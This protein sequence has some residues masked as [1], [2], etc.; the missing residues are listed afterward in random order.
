MRIAPFIVNYMK[1][2]LREPL[3]HFLPDR[4]AFFR[5][6]TRATCTWPDRR[7]RSAAISQ[8]Q[9]PNSSSAPSNAFTAIA[10]AP[11]NRQIVYAGNATSI[12][13]SADAGASW[14][15]V[16]SSTDR[17]I[18][19]F[20][21]RRT[22]EVVAATWD[23]MN[24]DGSIYD[25]TDLGKSF[26][27]VFANRGLSTITEDDRGL[28]WTGGKNYGI[29]EAA[30]HTTPDLVQWTPILRYQDIAAAVDCP[31]GTV[32]HDKCAANWCVLATQLGISAPDCV[33]AI[34]A[35]PLPGTTGGCCDGS[36]GL[37]GT[38]PGLVAIALVRR[39]PRR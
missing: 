35:P 11:S 14:T 33:V 29:G 21:A 27:V 17:P 39:R 7:A 22:G 12:Y 13:R 9:T 16:L 1:R 8:P 5:M 26:G 37:A 24:M 30:I 3:L 31:A 32:Q 2:L 18:D 19:A 15:P 10:F 6:C 4:P 38:L 20:A 28:L 23:G 25:S 34:E 36:G